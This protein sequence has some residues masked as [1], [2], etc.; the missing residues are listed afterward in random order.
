MTQD[1]FL[2]ALAGKINQSMLGTL[3]ELS[4][5]AVVYV[6]ATHLLSIADSGP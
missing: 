3:L 5:G 1:H 4:T 6:S 2:H